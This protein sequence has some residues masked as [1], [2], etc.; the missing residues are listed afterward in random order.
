MA[1]LNPP[2]FKSP[3]EYLEY[4]RAERRAGRLPRS[5]AAPEIDDGVNKFFKRYYDINI[6]KRENRKW[7]E[8]QTQLPDPPREKQVMEV[9]MMER[10]KSQPT[11][12]QGTLFGFG[13]QP[14]SNQEDSAAPTQGTLFGFGPQAISNPEAE[15]KEVDPNQ[16]SFDFEVD[17][18]QQSFNFD[19]AT[20]ESK[21]NTEVQKDLL[22]SIF[23]TLVDI[24]KNVSLMTE[25]FP[26]LL[27]ASKSVDK[28]KGKNKLEEREKEQESMASRLKASG[29]NVIQ[30]TAQGVFGFFEKIFAILTPFILG[31]ALTLTDLNNPVQLLK[32]AFKVLAAFLVGKFIYQLGKALTMAFISKLLQNFIGPKQILAPN[33]TI[34]TSGGVPGAGGP[35]GGPVGGGGKP[36]G[37]PSGKPGRFGGLTRFGTGVL[38]TIGLTSLSGGATPA[39]AAAVPTGGFMRDDPKQLANINRNLQS[40]LATVGGAGPAAPAATG[41]LG[42]LKG[43]APMLKRIGGGGLL[44]A[45]FMVPMFM[46]KRDEGK[47]TVRAGTETGITLAGGLGGAKLGAMVGTAIAP[48]IGTAIGLVLG[49]IAGS[50]FADSFSESIFNFF[51]GE[52][53]GGTAKKGFLFSPEFAMMS[54]EE[55]QQINI[56]EQDYQEFNRRFEPKPVGEYQ[57]LELEELKQARDKAKQVESIQDILARFNG[58]QPTNIVTQFNSSNKTS[59]LNPPLAADSAGVTWRGFPFL[60]PQRNP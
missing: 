31:L 56:D 1:N 36:S 5:P 57:T 4:A 9:E 46:A 22:T 10:E 44:S 30:N 19:S 32:D 54:E 27:E 3:K 17:P 29:A 25:G 6:R 16:Q 13:P 12:T 21:A 48:G 2:L 50:V 55:K 33:S 24:S 39:A 42:K 40:G 23:N 53:T 11:P 58:G 45:I 49:G 20:E 26:D 52:P 60:Y 38:S 37:K 34:I 7:Y 8:K 18:N 47:S 15:E 51:G 28:L 35:V 59:V 41:V 14:I 43:A